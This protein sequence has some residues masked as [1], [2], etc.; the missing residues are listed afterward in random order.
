MY[1]LA[2]LDNFKIQYKGKHHHGIK[3]QSLCWPLCGS[4]ILFSA[5]V[6]GLKSSN[7][8]NSNN[9]NSNNNNDNNSSNNNSNNNM[10]TMTAVIIKAII[11]IIL[12]SNN[13]KKS[14]Q[15]WHYIRRL[16]MI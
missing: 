11:M 1:F 6:W 7:S 12:V 14:N 9:N 5:K 8:N 4:N 3:N 2:S 13:F 10:T 16:C 15:K